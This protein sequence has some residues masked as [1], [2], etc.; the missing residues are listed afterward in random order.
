VE[1]LESTAQAQLRWREQLAC[2]RSEAELRCE[3]RIRAAVLERA[4]S[5]NAVA[6]LA[7]QGMSSLAGWKSASWTV[8]CGG[9]QQRWPSTS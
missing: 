5:S 4:E 9:F 6:L 1:G 7:A 3:P 8:K 2:W